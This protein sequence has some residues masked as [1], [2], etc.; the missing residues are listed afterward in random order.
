[1]KWKQLHQVKPLSQRQMYN[2]LCPR[3]GIRRHLFLFCPIRLSVTLS[4]WDSVAKTLTFSITFS[5]LEI[6]ISYFTC[7]LNQWNTFKWPLFFFKM[8]FNSAVVSYFNKLICNNYPE[9]LFI[10]YDTNVLFAVSKPYRRELIKSMIKQK[11]VVCIT[12]MITDNYTLSQCMKKGSSD[13][14][15]QSFISLMKFKI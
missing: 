9:F 6:E 13:I 11:C 10:I 4:V 14:E 1:M 7:I 8:I 15:N 2:F 3:N 12:E 5:Q